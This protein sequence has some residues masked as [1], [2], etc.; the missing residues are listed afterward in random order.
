[1]GKFIYEF[2]IEYSDITKNNALSTKGMLRIMQEVAGLASSK[3][4]YGLNDIPKTNVTWLLLNWKLEMIKR[5]IWNSKIKIVTWPRET[6]RLSSFRDFEVYDEKEEIIAKASSKWILINTDLHKLTPITEKMIQE[7]DCLEEAVFDE[8]FNAKLKE[9]KEYDSSTVY[10]IERRDI[11]SNNHVNNLC[12]LDF[13]Y[14]VLPEHIY[15]KELDCL[16][17]VEI[18]YKKEIRAGD[19]VVFFY[20]EQDKKHIITIKSKDEKILHSII[21]LYH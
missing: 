18:M 9:P 3:V 14:Q 20:K 4:G 12:Y 13:A 8:P 1:M 17:H 10:R 15:E 2:N 6:S 7:Y 19:E 16:N 5:P 11:D 21:Y